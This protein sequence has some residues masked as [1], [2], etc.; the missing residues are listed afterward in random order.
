VRDRFGE[1]GIVG[2]LMAQAAGKSFVID[3]F[4]LSCRVIGRTVETAMLAHLCEEA[5][6]RNLMEL[7]GRI[8]PTAKNAP[9]RQLFQQHGFDKTSETESGE[10]FWKLVLKERTVAWPDWMKI[11]AGDSVSGKE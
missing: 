2:F 7:H 5:G 9:V 11:Y 3:S 8:I 1:S 6:K 10:S 4:L